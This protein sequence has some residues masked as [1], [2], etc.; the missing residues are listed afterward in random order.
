M[1]TII[2]ILALSLSTMLHS[3]AQ[4]KKL[5]NLEIWYQKEL[6]NPAC[7]LRGAYIAGKGDKMQMS[8]FQNI[9]GTKDYIVWMGEKTWVS[10]DSTMY[11]ISDTGTGFVTITCYIARS[12]ANGGE[13]SVFSSNKLKMTYHISNWQTSEITLDGQLYMKKGMKNDWKATYKRTFVGSDKK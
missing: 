6:Y 3:P 11:D 12:N 8:Y 10:T 5:K 2:I 9:E 13:P 4:T 7:P 1:K